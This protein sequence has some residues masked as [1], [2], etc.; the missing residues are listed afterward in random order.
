MSSCNFI[1]AA[2]QP[3]SLFRFATARTLLPL[4]KWCLWGGEPMGG[5]SSRASYGGCVVDCLIVV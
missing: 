4:Q 3:A 2:A 1:G 5:C